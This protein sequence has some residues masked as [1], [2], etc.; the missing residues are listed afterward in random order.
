[1]PDDLNFIKDLG[2][3]QVL[4]ELREEKDHLSYLRASP[5]SLKTKHPCGLMFQKVQ[6]KS[7]SLAVTDTAQFLCWQMSCPKS[8]SSKDV[9]KFPSL[10]SFHY[11]M[12]DFDE[13]GLPVSLFWSNTDIGCHFRFLLLCVCASMIS[14]FVLKCFYEV[15]DNGI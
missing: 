5:K 6:V 9:E 13:N 11:F 2:G 8:Y 3:E 4:Q 14:V 15:T 12:Q 7:A 10:C 1:M